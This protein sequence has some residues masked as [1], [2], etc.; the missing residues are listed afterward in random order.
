MKKKKREEERTATGRGEYFIGNS[1]NHRVRNREA[2]R[3]FSFPLFKDDLQL[4]ENS[5]LPCP[6]PPPPLPPVCGWPGSFAGVPEQRIVKD[7]PIFSIFNLYAAMRMIDA[8]RRCNSHRICIPAVFLASNFDV[9]I[10]R[11]DR[12]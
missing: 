2:E 3:R 10:E 11:R 5:R 1:E 7:K 9:F 6:S 4:N 8:Q 12:R